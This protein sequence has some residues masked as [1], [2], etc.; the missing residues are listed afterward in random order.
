VW[1][2]TTGNQLRGHDALRFIRI[3]TRNVCAINCQPSSRWHRYEHDVIYSTSM[4]ERI[5]FQSNRQS[6]SASTILQLTD[7]W[8][9]CAGLATAVTGPQPI[10]LPCVGLHETYGVCK[11]SKHGT[12]TT[13]NSQHC[14]IFE[15]FCK[16]TRS[17]V[18]G[19]R[20]CIQADK[21]NFER[22]AW[23]ANYAHCALNLSR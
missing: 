17:L 12:K 19:F 23:I 6:V 9:R 21:G 4:T 10:H 13:P 7:R 18:R 20:K 5:S 2:G 16:I 14:K 15:V 1:W 8:Q 22:L 11:R 3:F